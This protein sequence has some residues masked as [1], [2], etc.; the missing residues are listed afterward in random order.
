MQ[1]FSLFLLNYHGILTQIGRMFEELDYV[2]EGQN[3]EL[4]ADLYT[5]QSGRLRH[6]GGGCI[7]RPIH[8]HFYPLILPQF[9]FQEGGGCQSLVRI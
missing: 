5:N 7:S 8:P 4:F 1:M 9:P 2:K 3:A 6:L